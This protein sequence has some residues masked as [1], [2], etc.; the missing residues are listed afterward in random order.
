MRTR[1]NTERRRQSIEYRASLTTAEKEHQTAV[2]IPADR[3]CKDIICLKTRYGVI[4]Q[5]YLEHKERYPWM[6]EKMVQYSLKN[7]S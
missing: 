3:I 2:L 5:L 6:T 4:R 1:G 7:R